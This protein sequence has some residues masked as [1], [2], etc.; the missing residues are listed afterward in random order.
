MAGCLLLCCPRFVDLSAT[1]WS[2]SPRSQPS[3]GLQEQEAPPPSSLGATE[4]QQSQPP[5]VRQDN[6]GLFQEMGRLFDKILPLKK[7]DE[8]GAATSAAPSEG[9]SGAT[10]DA[11][12]GTG[13]TLSRLAKPST[14]V[15]GR[16]V[17]PLATNRTPDCKMAADKLCQS[18]GYKEGKS[19]NSDAAESCSPKVLIPGRA[20]KPD[21]CRTD[22][23]VTSAL[24]Q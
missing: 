2:Q 7:S 22:T 23:Y 12:K 20:R 4:L 17:C 19:L 21:D 1:G 8:G 14:M 13:E 24:C 18:K 9:T 11:L 16:S 3:L 15:T 10:S 6:P 5:P